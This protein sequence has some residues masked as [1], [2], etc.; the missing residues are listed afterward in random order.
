MFHEKVRG[1]QADI[2]SLGEYYTVKGDAYPLLVSFAVICGTFWLITGILGFVN[3]KAYFTLGIINTIIFTVVFTCIYERVKNELPCARYND[4]IGNTISASY[5]IVTTGVP[6]KAAWAYYGC[7]LSDDWYA[8]HGFD[9]YDFFWVSSLIC[10]ILTAYQLA[11]AA[12]L[13][14]EEYE[15]PKQQSYA[16]IPTE[17]KLGE[18]K[19]ADQPKTDNKGSQQTSQ[20]PTSKPQDNSTPQKPQDSSAPQKPPENPATEKPAT[21]KPA[22]DKPKETA[23]ELKK[24]TFIEVKKET[25][26]E[27]TTITTTKKTTDNQSLYFMKEVTTTDIQQEVNA[28]TIIV[29]KSGPKNNLRKEEDDN[30]EAK[31]DQAPP[32]VE[33]VK[34]PPKEAK[35]VDEQITEHAGKDQNRAEEGEE[36]Q[37]PEQE[38]DESIDFYNMK[39]PEEVSPLPTFVPSVAFTTPTKI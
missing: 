16:D 14:Y 5:M 9:S 19:E 4:M 29:E 34:E 3:R 13:C 18:K 39:P 31:K 15:K 25:K 20:N 11:C 28:E 38:E 37:K 6:T 10:F 23:T 22:T 1:M 26:A 36:K 8:K 33:E 21:E 2:E 7:K 27:E 35:P 17:A 30:P 12:T 24:E 32:K